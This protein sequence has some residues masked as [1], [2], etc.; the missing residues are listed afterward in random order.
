VAVPF[1][2]LW[3][4]LCHHLL[5]IVGN[6]DP[7]QVPLENANEVVVGHARVLDLEALIA[8]RHVYRLDAWISEQQLSDRLEAHRA[9]RTS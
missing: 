6:L 2:D 9:V 7:V 1:A 3:D 5:A 4:D 8:E